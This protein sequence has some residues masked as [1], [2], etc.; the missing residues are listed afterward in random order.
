MCYH[1]QNDIP[2]DFDVN[3]RCFFFFF[4]KGCFVTLMAVAK[5]GVGGGGRGGGKGEEGGGRS[6]E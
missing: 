6:G 1:Q 4:P 2:E 3:S 5:R